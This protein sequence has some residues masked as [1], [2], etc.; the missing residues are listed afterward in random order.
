MSNKQHNIIIN[1][2]GV[3]PLRSESYSSEKDE[4]GFPGIPPHTFVRKYEHPPTWCPMLH[5]LLYKIRDNKHIVQYATGVSVGDSNLSDVDKERGFVTVI[6]TVDENSRFVDIKL[7]EASIDT[8]IKVLSIVK[9]E[10][11]NK[12]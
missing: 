8:L 11:D 3:C 9:H 2:C 12:L 4:C 1:R 10:L 5:P 7:T 6:G